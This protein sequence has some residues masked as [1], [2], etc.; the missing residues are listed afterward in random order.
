MLLPL[1]DS[2]VRTQSLKFHA[3][4]A[5]VC[6]GFGSAD[7]LV[8]LASVMYIAYFLQR[9]GYGALPL[10]RFHEAEDVM[11]TA[12]RRGAQTDT[13]LLDDD[14]YPVF[15]ALLTLHDRQLA[16]APAHAVVAA[17]GELMRFID[18]AAPSPL[19]PRPVESQ[20]TPA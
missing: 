19:P 2:A 17:E 7:H 16:T 9:A 20:A 14:G 11:E 10:E 1:P 4:L 18:G 5:T 3:C 15:G 6:C 8:E 13:W 12:N